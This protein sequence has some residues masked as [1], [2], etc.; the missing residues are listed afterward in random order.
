MIPKPLNEI[1]WSDIEALRDSGREEDDTIEFK[2]SFSGGSDF[3]AFNDKQRNDAVDGIAKEVIAFLNG[4]GGDVVIG[5]KEFKNEHPKIEALLPVPNVN[6]TV[7]RLGQALAAVIEPTQSILAV[8]AI[9]CPI[10]VDAGVI[11]V[12][13]PSSL[14]APHRSKRL[15]ECYIRRGR[16]SVPM[17]MDE[18]QDLTLLR[19]ARRSELLARLDAALVDIGH[20]KVR[21]VTLPNDRLR[22]KMA[23]Q[24]YV[25]GE[26]PISSEVLSA[27]R[28][29][30][31]VM[32]MNG[33]VF[34]HLSI[35]DNLEHQ[36]KPMLRGRIFEGW[37]DRGARQVYCSASISS[38]LAVEWDYVDSGRHTNNNSE[39]EIGLYDAWAIGFFARALFSLKRLFE[40]NAPFAHGVLRVGYFCNGVQKLLVGDGHWGEAFDLPEERII[41]PDFEISEISGLEDIFAQIQE[42]FYSI[43]GVDNPEKFGISN[44]Q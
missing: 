16:E 12:R 43:A 38:S 3:L 1:E 7:D 2:S 5:A 40:L 37:K 35:F 6:Q 4:R 18:V 34:D 9:A 21:R 25:T 33:R 11:V 24:P 14:R 13:A 44:W 19:T 23:Y 30:K 41:F 42:D 17:P 31:P 8:R 29:A 22:L 32:S 28:Q 27:L 36:G 10:D 39:A 15:K 26:I 20:L